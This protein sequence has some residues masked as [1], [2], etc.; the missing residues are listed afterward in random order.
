MVMDHV[1]RNVALHEPISIGLDRDKF[2][3]TYQII[4]IRLHF[5][6]GPTALFEWRREH[7]NEMALLGNSRK[8]IWRRRT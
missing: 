8:T 4:N 3:M 1:L 2:S 5:Q 7:L 6:S